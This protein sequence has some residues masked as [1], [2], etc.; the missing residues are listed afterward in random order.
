ML[1]QNSQ[2]GYLQHKAAEYDPSPSCH[3][4]SQATARTVAGGCNP[5]KH[6]SMQCDVERRS[7]TSLVYKCVAAACLTRQLGVL[8][9]LDGAPQACLSQHEVRQHKAVQIQS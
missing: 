6:D 7:C 8:A 2:T 1:Q 3:L 5:V 4:C 9:E